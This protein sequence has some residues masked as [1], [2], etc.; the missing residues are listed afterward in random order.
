LAQQSRIEPRFTR[1]NKKV[2]N[3]RSHQTSQGR[4]PEE[5]DWNRELTSAHGGGGG[6][7]LRRLLRGEETKKG[8]G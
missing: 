8:C 3:K 2:I 1:E 5:N 7:R 6:G 4:N